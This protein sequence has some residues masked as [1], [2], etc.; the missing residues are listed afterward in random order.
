MPMLRILYHEQPKNQALIKLFNLSG[1]KKNALNVEQK[2][3]WGDNL[4]KRFPTEVKTQMHYALKN[5]ST[6]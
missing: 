1:K 3:V 4:K 6:L 2:D 5:Y